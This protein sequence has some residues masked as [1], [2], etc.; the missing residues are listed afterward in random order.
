MGKLNRLAW[1]KKPRVA[2][3]LLVV[4]LL[5]AVLVLAVHNMNSPAQGSISEAPASQQEKTDPYANPGTYHGKYISF[6]YPAHYKKVPSKITG[7]Y[8]ETVDYHTTD[9]SAKQI[10]VGVYRGSMADD[11]GVLY[12][13]NHKE[14]YRENDSQIGVEFIK[15]DGTEDTFFIEHDSLFATVSATAP[16]GGLIGEALIVASNLKWI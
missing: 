6:T 7:N 1:L 11:S 16:Y 12:R 4:I 15:N 14:L 10:S 9:D 13:R 8:L 2:V 5:V 3:P